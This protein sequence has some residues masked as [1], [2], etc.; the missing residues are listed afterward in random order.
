MMQPRKKPPSH[1][2]ADHRMH[3]PEAAAYVGLAEATLANFRCQ[4]GGPVFHKVGRRI[5]YIKSDL[6]TWLSACRRTANEQ[7]RKPSD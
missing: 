2:F 4:G 3:A 7:N 5:V 1:T 6:D